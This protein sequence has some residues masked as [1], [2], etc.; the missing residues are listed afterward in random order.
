MKLFS[1]FIIDSEYYVKVEYINVT[2]SNKPY[3][4]ILK[5]CPTEECPFD[6]FTAIYQ[7]R[8]PGSATVECSKKVP[9]SKFI[10]F[11]NK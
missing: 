5:G 7:F 2:D 4:Y 6:I 3:P 1:W 11:N 10:L 8:F 9:P